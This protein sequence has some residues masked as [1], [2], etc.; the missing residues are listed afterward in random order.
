MHNLRECPKTYLT[1]FSHD[2]IQLHMWSIAYGNALP[3]AGGL[4]DQIAVVME[5]LSVVRDE[6]VKVEAWRRHEEKIKA[7]REKEVQKVAGKQSRQ[8]RS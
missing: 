4:N 5:A 8:R 1:Q 6:L 3:D 7:D 2:V